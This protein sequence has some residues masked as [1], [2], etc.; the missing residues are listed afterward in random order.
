MDMMIEPRG[1]TILPRSDYSLRAA[2]GSSPATAELLHHG[3]HVTAVGA[4]RIDAQFQLPDGSAIVFASD[5]TPFKEV[6]NILL[7]GPDL[8]VRDLLRVGGA[9]TPGFLAYAEAHAEGQIAF[10]WHDHEQV[11]TVRHRRRWF[12]LASS[13]LRVDDLVPQRPLG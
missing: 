10:C 7:V 13:W 3:R 4:T 9:T 12:G 8:Q 11:L 1:E 6:L 2:T 5:D